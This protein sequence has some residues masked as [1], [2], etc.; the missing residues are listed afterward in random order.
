[1]AKA[2]ICYL[3]VADFDYELSPKRLP[4]AGPVT[5]PAARATWGIAGESGP[6]SRALPAWR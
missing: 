1:M 5:A 4:L 2:T 3:V 6:T